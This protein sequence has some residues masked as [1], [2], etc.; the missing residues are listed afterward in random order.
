LE[1][2]KQGVSS[3]DIT[4]EFEMTKEL[5][6]EIGNT[7]VD[8][9]ESFRSV[10]RFLLFM[11]YNV[12][13]TEMLARF[14]ERDIITTLARTQRMYQNQCTAHTLFVLISNHQYDRNVEFFHAPKARKS[15]LQQKRTF[16]ELSKGPQSH[17]TL[18]PH[19]HQTLKA[20]TNH[21]PIHSLLSG[22]PNCAT[23]VI[24]VP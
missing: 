2:Q 15:S 22:V 9:T 12:L 24:Y 7:F 14:P 23:S 20:E 19:H 13:V 21:F 1:V 11:F 8:K 5:I 17:P 18:L 10:T 3:C 4:H 6:P 16:S